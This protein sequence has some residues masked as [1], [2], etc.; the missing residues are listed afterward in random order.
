MTQVSTL[1]SSAR[2]QRSRSKEGIA[3][4]RRAEAEHDP[5]AAIEQRVL[6]LRAS[7]IPAAS[8]ADAVSARYNQMR[9]EI[10]RIIDAS[11]KKRLCEEIQSPL[12]EARKPRES[13]A[14]HGSSRRRPSGML[15]S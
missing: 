4:L 7:R 15:G 11:N 10:D 1:E 5:L 13:C 2:D 6:E 14:M 8:R 12:K 3:R 9:A